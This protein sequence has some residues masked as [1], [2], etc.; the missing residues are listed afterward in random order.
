MRKLLPWLMLAVLAALGGCRSFS[1]CQSP[2]ELA[3]GGKT[4]PP[5]RVPVGLEAPDTTG[6]L[7]IPE[8]NEPE[9]PRKEDEPCLD[10][11]PSYFPDRTPGAEAEKPPG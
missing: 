11:P 8:L 1:A 2:E 5:L 3:E 7:R 9:R 4:I 10:T 6:A